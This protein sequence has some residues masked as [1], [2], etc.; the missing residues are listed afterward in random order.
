MPKP[1]RSLMEAFYALADRALGESG[2]D[3]YA[4]LAFDGEESDFVRLSQGRVRQPGRVEQRYGTLRVAR[5]AKSASGRVSLSGDLEADALELSVLRAV[6]HAQLEVLPEDPHLLLPDE[7]RSSEDVQEDCLPPAAEAVAR[8]LDLA[9]GL[10][11]VG[12]WASGGVH[13]GYADSRGQRNW[14]SSYP[15]HFDF[16]LHRRNDKAVKGSYAGVSWDDAAFAARLEDMRSRLAVMER[17]PRSVTPGRYRA[18]LSPAALD[19][20][21]GVLAWG[22]FGLKDRKT[23]QTSLLRMSEAGARLHSD[24]TLIENTRDGVGP[25]FTASGFEKP[26]RVTLIAKGQLKDPL[27]SP[28][29]AKEYGVS[30]TGSEASEVPNSLD[31][32]AGSLATR[33]V[34][35]RLGTG[36]HIGNL[37]YLNYSDRQS[38]RVTGMTRFATFWVEGGEV[39][40]PVDVMRFDDTLYRLLGESLEGLTAERELLLDASSYGARSLRSARLPGAL[41]GEMSFTL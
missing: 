37:W 22:G 34:L 27:V 33:D 30:H 32:C 26:A 35:P 36:L 19:E 23:K 38:C 40:A 16:S 31:L 41:V 18:Y 8:V 13:A 10:D 28:R 3:E 9:S 2:P 7:V 17:P 6:L 12:I 29:S 11:L 5:G 39:V 15:F 20:L 14:F 4:S 1:D 21:L 25:C 24:V